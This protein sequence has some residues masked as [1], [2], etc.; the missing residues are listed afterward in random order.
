MTI[1]DF[2]I[3]FQMLPTC[4][5]L[6]C[7]EVPK[8]DNGELSTPMFPSTHAASAVSYATAGQQST[9]EA[10]IDPFL[11]ASRF[12]TVFHDREIS[13]ADFNN[14]MNFDRSRPLP[15]HQWEGVHIESGAVNRIYWQNMRL[16]GTFAF[17]NLPRT[18]ET[19]FIDGNDFSGVFETRYIP[20]QMGF[21]TLE[22]NRFSGT[23]DWPN[24]P[25]TL[26]TLDVRN[27]R[28]RGVIDLRTVP[29]TL[30]TIYIRGN[31]IRVIRGIGQ[32]VWG[33]EDRHDLDQSYSKHADR[34]AVLEESGFTEESFAVAEEG[35]VK[36]EVDEVAA[37]TAGKRESPL[38]EE[39]RGF[40]GIK[41]E[42]QEEESTDSKW[43]IRI[44]RYVAYAVF[45]VLLVIFS[46]VF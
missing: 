41:P 38:I 12:Y 5:T 31:K 26:T 2:E 29:R 30:E 28:L 24:L 16:G 46:N 21:M 15:A 40:H 25:E 19:L 35:D 44:E 23:I 13:V 14:S 10:L 32:D 20:K 45:W 6:S 43:N 27:N 4:L 36:G 22:G 1:F 11:H 33:G 39:E 3:L 34:S 18:L 37:E 7:L 42:I 9:M 8:R 17:R